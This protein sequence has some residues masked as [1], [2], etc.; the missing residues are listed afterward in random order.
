[1][2]N[3]HEIDDSTENTM[4]QLRKHL[5]T[6]LSPELKRR[7]QQSR[8]EAIEAL[9]KKP[10]FSIPSLVPA[11][12][13]TAALALG[14]GIAWN[15]LQESPDLQNYSVSNDELEIEEVL[16]LAESEFSDEDFQILLADDE[17]PDLDFF[18]WASAQPEF[19][20]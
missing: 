4:S 10:I 6:E 11:I 5:N 15:T 16:F 20:E 18:S 13:M 19:M 7:L 14:V 2:S 17:N 1:M 8:V 9:D 3:N 12:G